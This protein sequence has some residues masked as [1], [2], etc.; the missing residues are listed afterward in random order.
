M[1]ELTNSAVINDAVYEKNRNGG[2][3]IVKLAVGTAPDKDQCEMEM[4][5]DV[6]SFT[7]P[8][9]S[10]K[11]R[12]DQPVSDT[13][14]VPVYESGETVDEKECGCRRYTLERGKSRIITGRKVLAH[15]PVWAWAAIAVGYAPE[16]SEYPFLVIEAADTFG[17]EGSNE[18]EMIGFIEERLHEMT[19]RLVR[20]AKLYD[21]PLA[22]MRV[23]YKYV[24]V[25]PEQVGKAKV[26]EL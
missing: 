10:E 14:K 18:S 26:K 17:S 15:G 21:L 16:G 6:Y 9:E 13:A 12:Y 8:K 2:Y 1:K 22:A 25:E 3:P 19:A 4:E 7:F 23:A 20:R 24:F 11:K 5:Y